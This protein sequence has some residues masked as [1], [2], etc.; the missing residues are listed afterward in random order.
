MSMR[1]INCPAAPKCSE[2]G[3]GATWGS[4]VS[5]TP[6]L[7]SSRRSS[8]SMAIARGPHPSL[9]HASFEL[10]GI[11]EY[12]RGTGR[13]LRAALLSMGAK[14]PLV[15]LSATPKPDVLAQLLALTAAGRLHP[16]IARTAP[17]A[18][19]GDALA[20]VADGHVTGKIVVLAD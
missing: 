19:A 2:A 7:S 8:W 14:R 5:A 13:L 20:E 4:T 1:R 11:D 15:P 17:F 18:D 12:M 9:H 10:R 16:V 6:R 3:N